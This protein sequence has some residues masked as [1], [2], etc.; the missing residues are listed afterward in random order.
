VDVGES[1]ESSIPKPA[2]N[3]WIKLVFPAPKSPASSKQL[4]ALSRAPKYNPNCLVAAASGSNPVN[5][6]ISVRL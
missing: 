2:P 3:P 1:I 5:S 6:F 4:P